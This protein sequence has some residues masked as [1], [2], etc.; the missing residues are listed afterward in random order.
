MEDGPLLQI[1][2]MIRSSSLLSFG[3]GIAVPLYY[4][5]L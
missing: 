2:S 5:M 1:V 4:M 3:E